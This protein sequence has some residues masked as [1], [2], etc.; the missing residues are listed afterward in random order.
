MAIILQVSPR[1]HRYLL[2]SQRFHYLLSHPPMGQ[3]WVMTSIGCTKLTS[4]DKIADLILSNSSWPIRSKRVI[5]IIL[6]NLRLWGHTHSHPTWLLL[7]SASLHLRVLLE[8]H[9][10]NDK[11][12]DLLLLSILSEY[13][14]RLSRYQ[15]WC[16]T[17]SVCVCGSSCSGLTPAWRIMHKLLDL[18][19]KGYLRFAKV[20]S[21]YS[22]QKL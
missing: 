15:L 2:V 11:A 12:L 14:V 20:H 5:I 9:P 7:L 1:F 17:N 6:G 3:N 16:D 22:L 18:G 19:W 13:L 8:R 4:L 10:M 21:T